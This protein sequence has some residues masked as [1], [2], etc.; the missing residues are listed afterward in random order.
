MT[1]SP[2]EQTKNWVSQVI[3]GYNFCPFA[4]KEVVNNT[5]EYV[6]S[7]TESH[8]DAVI[9][10]LSLIQ[11]MR[12]NDEIE[13][14]LHIFSKGFQNFDDFLDLVDLANAM[15]VSSGYEGFIQIANFHPDYVFADS[16]DSDAAN[17][18]NRAPYPTLHLIR[19]AS[20]A[21]VLDIHPDPEGIP[22][23]NIKLAREKG[24]TFWQQLL[25]HCQTAKKD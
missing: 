1:L 6:D 7:Q 13:T 4:K 3:V 9:E 2:I 18:T 22:E 12:E 25:N 21:R 20:M 15:L 11:Q 8:E 23:T 10:M 5:I 19:E 24:I 17:Y 14:C 16:D